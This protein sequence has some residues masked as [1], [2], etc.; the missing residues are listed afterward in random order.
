MKALLAAILI[1][2]SALT[3]IAFGQTLGTA[4]TYQ[5]ELQS[6]SI[7]YTGSADIQ[8]RA[9]TTASGVVTIGPE[10]TL[11]DIDCNAGRFT[12]T[13]DFLQELPAGSHLEIRVRTPHDPTNTIPFTTLIP[14][15]AFLPAPQATLAARAETAATALNASQ[16]A[17]NAPSFYQNAANLSAGSIPSARLTGT[18][19]SIL[20]LTNASNT[21]AGSGALLSNLNAASIATGTLSPARGGTGTSIAAATTGS[22]LKWNGSAFVAGADNDTL[23]AAGSGLAL[24]GTTFSIPTNGVIGAMIAGDT[25]EAV[26]LAVDPASLAKVSSNFLFTNGTALGVG[27]TLPAATLHVGTATPVINVQS[28]ANGGDATL[29]LFETAA[30]PVG[31]QLHYDGTT[32]LFQI[33]TIGTPGAAIIPAISIARGTSNVSITGTL[34]AATIAIPTTTRSV[35]LPPAAFVPS[36]GNTS[37]ALDSTGLYNT[38]GSGVQAQFYAPVNVPDG[39]TITGFSFRCLDNDGTVDM[40]VELHTTTL[41]TGAFAATAVTTSFG[42]ANLRTFSSGTL[43]L[44]VD[45][46]LRTLTVR[47]TWAGPLPTSNV[48]RLIAVRVDYTIA[49]PLP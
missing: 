9:F 18:Y 49:T 12:A 37:Y 32:N 27:T 25:I 11:S 48:M 3:P 30:G 35:I 36:S 29:N 28:T 33:G 15:Q 26:D 10:I 6:G 2:A 7:P 46:T 19:S 44:P 47:A 20:S 38:G 42:N 45:H 5:G 14:R 21:F 1:S 24:S 41:S 4:F 40:T 13:L 34:T 8:F 22:V 17:G 16:F 43:N 23:F 31:A 39:A